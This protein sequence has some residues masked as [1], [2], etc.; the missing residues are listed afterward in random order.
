MTRSSVL[1]RI[2]KI[3]NEK[4]KDCPVRRE[5]AKKY[6]GRFALQDGH[7]NKNC[8]V[9]AELQSLGKML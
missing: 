2:D 5:M 6:K 7:C 3:L 8:Q 1:F 4:C 9:G